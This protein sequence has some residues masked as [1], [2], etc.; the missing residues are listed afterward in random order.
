MQRDWQDIEG[1][2]SNKRKT[3][4]SQRT[5]KMRVKMKVKKK[6][7]RRTRHRERELRTC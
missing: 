2:T 7:D 1:Q 4:E 3:G 6:R 5:V